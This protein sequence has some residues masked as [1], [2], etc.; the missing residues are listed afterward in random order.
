MIKKNNYHSHNYFFNA[1]N[2]N[3]DYMHKEIVEIL[4]VIL[5]CLV[6]LITLFFVTKMIGKKQVSNLAFLIMSSVF[7][8]ATSPLKWP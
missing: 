5:R 7:R 1:N 2:I 8:S 6:S 4:D 3:G